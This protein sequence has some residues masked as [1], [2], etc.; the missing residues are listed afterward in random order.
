MHLLVSFFFCLI[1]CTKEKN[2]ADS[3]QQPNN[4]KDTSADIET[5]IDNNRILIKKYLTIISKSLVGL[6]NNSSFKN[7]VYTEVINGI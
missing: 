4:Y 3:K 5:T 1:S 2:L 7:A 6:M